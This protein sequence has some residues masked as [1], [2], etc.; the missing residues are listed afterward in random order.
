[1]PE[2]P[3]LTYNREPGATADMHNQT[4][5]LVDTNWKILSLDT[6]NLGN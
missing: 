4:V 3:L 5:Q 2:C 6:I 1:M